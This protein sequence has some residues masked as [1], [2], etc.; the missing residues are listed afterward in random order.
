MTERFVGM[1]IGEGSTPFVLVAK[2]E[3]GKRTE[4]N[5][6]DFPRA[7]RCI[8]KKSD[9]KRPICLSKMSKNQA[10][11]GFSLILGRMIF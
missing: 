7:L 1:L 8:G 2:G 3:R 5:E 9:L 4:M 10:L 6:V 11:V